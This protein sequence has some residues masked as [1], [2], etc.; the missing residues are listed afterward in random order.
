[1]GVKRQ[2]VNPGVWRSAGELAGAMSYLLEL[3]ALEAG[4]PCPASRLPPAERAIAGHLVQ[5]GLLRPFRCVLQQTEG[6]RNPFSGAEQVQRTQEGP[7]IIREDESHSLKN[8]C[9]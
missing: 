1:M 6:S 9:S 7:T 5:L 8:D 3:S 2:W 4:R